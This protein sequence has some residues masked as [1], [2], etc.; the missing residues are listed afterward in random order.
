[1]V[2]GEGITA[3]STSRDDPE[4]VDR[5][6]L[7]NRQFIRSVMRASGAGGHAVTLPSDALEQAGVDDT[8]ELVVIPAEVAGGLGLQK[9]PLFLVYQQPLVE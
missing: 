1:M 8:D 2:L 6:L 5:W 7:R 4:S 9:D 3:M